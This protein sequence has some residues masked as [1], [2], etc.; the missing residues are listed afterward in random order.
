MSQSIAG[1]EGESDELLLIDSEG[2]EPSIPKSQ[3]IH[4]AE[5]VMTPT[6]L[7]ELTIMAANSRAMMDDE[8]EEAYNKLRQSIE[9]VAQDLVRATYITPSTVHN[10][11]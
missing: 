10:I 2:A 4:R 5:G 9:S 6:V 11:A 3:F 8:S 1:V 7:E